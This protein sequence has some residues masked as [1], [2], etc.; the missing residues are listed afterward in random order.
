[1][2]VPVDLLLEPVVFPQP[3]KFEWLKDGQP[4]RQSGLTTTY[5]S[6]TFTSV[7]RTDAGNY[8]V[9]ATNFLLDDST[10][11][12]GSDTGSFYLDVVCKL[13]IN[14]IMF[15]LK[16]NIHVSCLHMSIKIFCCIIHIIVV[17]FFFLRSTFIYDTRSQRAIYTNG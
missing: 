8:T 17:V 14:V 15:E 7:M 6:V 3:F 11:P 2:N 4:L 9:N 10:Q 16:N 5:S 1:M 13:I 12:V